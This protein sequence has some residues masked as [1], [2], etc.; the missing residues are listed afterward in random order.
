TAEA[1]AEDLRRWLDGEPILARPAGAAER[2]WKWAKRRPAV[3]ALS[4]AAAL[5][6]VLGFAGVTWQWRQAVAQRDRA[7][8]AEREA[9]TEK[10]VT[11]AVHH[12][13][14]D[15][16]LPPPPPEKALRRQGPRAEVAPKPAAR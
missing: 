7:E 10:A 13:L 14:V 3:A 4:A 12:F 16:L 15:D 5:F 1:V 6:F 2:A 9:R 11:D 8:S